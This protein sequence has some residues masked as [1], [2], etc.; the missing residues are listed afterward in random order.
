MKQGH[1][2]SKLIP[3]F[4]NVLKIQLFNRNE[5]NNMFRKSKVGVLL[6]EFLKITSYQFKMDWKVLKELFLDNYL[7]YGIV[8]D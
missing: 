4:A 7:F 6:E 8:K 5:W 1:N 3:N 2:E